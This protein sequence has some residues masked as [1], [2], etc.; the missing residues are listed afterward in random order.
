MNL[1]ERAFKLAREN[2]EARILY[3]TR[4]PKDVIHSLSPEMRGD[5]IFYNQSNRLVF[6]NE[7]RIQFMNE[8]FVKNYLYG[9]QCS[10]IMLDMMYP[11]RELHDLCR[12]RIRSHI[13]HKDM[14]VYDLYGAYILY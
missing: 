2:P 8:D 12:V 13:K 10:H 11:D 5:W 1:I 3:I 14:G 7:S 4:L 6:N 9:A